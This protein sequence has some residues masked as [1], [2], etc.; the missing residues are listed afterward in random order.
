MN[1]HNTQGRPYDPEQR[2]AAEILR[3]RH[4]AWLVI[5]GSYSRHLWAFS[6]FSPIDGRPIVIASRQTGQP[7][8]PVHRD[9]AQR[10][11]RAAAHRHKRRQVG[12]ARPPRCH[13]PAD[14]QT[15]RRL[16]LS[17]DFAAARPSGY[18]REQ[19][20]GTRHSLEARPQGAVI[21]P[22]IRRAWAETSQAREGLTFPRSWTAQA[23]SSVGQMLRGGSAGS[24][25]G[26]GL[27]R[28]C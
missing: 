4:P 7:S 23:L 21:I 15:G 5:H 12:E 16:R 2:R 24:G 10:L 26:D 19:R 14:L 28:C 6:T 17:E 8:A 13:L 25:G 20:P 9:R 3:L 1:R 22:A 11:L 27:D 18:R